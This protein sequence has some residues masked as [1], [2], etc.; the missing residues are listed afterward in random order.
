VHIKTEKPVVLISAVN[1]NEGGPL[2]I[3][4]DA[5][6]TFMSACINDYRLV[7]LIHKREIFAE[8]IGNTAVEICEYKYP[9]RSWLLRAWFEY[10][11]CFFISKNIKP[12]VWI[13][14]NDITP[15]IVTKN[16]VVYCQNP[17][18]FYQLDSKQYFNEKKLLFFHFF[19]G[20]FYR[21]NIRSNKYVIV[22]QEWLKHA[23]IRRFKLNNVLVAH[24]DVLMPSIP[25]TH[26]PRSENFSFFFPAL[27]RAFKN[28]EV[29]ID[30]A[31]K[32]HERNKH[33]EVLFT[34]SGNE[35]SY[36]AK[37]VNEYHNR[38]YLKFIGIQSRDKIWSL[39]QTSSCLVFPSLMETWG[40]PISEA[41]LFN[42]PI[43]V[44]DLQYA[45]ETVG[46]YGKACFFDANDPVA[47]AGLME[48]AING[49]LQYDSPCYV[50]PQEPF[51]RSWKELYDL[52]LSGIIEN[53]VD[54][55]FKLSTIPDA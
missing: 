29:L 9:K 18:P 45:H 42:K 36:A 54:T 20:F 23:F 44:A 40:L 27:P 12:D 3:L 37:L 2:S 4:L 1:I 28:F 31:E 13:S 46:E 19:Y 14:L 11:H 22:Q 47:L 34:F 25:D 15:N 43:L 5:V 21:I 6:N 52:I 49:S 51:V 17:A 30:A 7:L 41:K 35:N 48:K 10:I 26:Q 55:Q 50:K 38:P 8:Y 39:Y 16:K 24:P 32:L 53:K 33:F